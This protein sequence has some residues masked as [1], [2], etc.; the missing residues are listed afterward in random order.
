MDAGLQYYAA[1]TQ[2]SH[3]FHFLRFLRNSWNDF[4]AVLEMVVSPNVSDFAAVIIPKIWG[5]VPHIPILLK[6]TEGI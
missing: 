6:T 5:S 4:R 2:T 1:T 3:L